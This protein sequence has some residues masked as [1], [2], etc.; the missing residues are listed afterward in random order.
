MTEI[1]TIIDAKPQHVDA[2][3][4]IYNQALVKRTATFETEPR[5]G[6]D[7]AGWLTGDVALKVAMVNGT[8]AGFAKVSSYRDRPCYVGIREYSVYVGDGFHRRGIARQL[9]QALIDDCRKVGVW[10]LLS[11]I[12]P[13]NIASIELAK[14]LGFRIVGTYHNHG[15]LDGVWKDCV[16]VE[17][18]L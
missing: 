6:D 14:Q 9:M 1:T 7:V 16:I 10:K 12:F 4:K 5:S 15:Q 11:R 18:C 17:L 8:P 2:V 3:A 13:E